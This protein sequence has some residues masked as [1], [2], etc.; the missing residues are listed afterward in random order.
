MLSD[1]A[2]PHRFARDL[3]AR[4]CCSVLLTGSPMAAL[5]GMSVE[6]AEHFRIDSVEEGG[7]SES[8]EMSSSDGDDEERVVITY[9]QALPTPPSHPTSEYRATRSIA[10]SRGRSSNAHPFTP[11]HTRGPFSDGSR[12]GSKGGR[13]S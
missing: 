6:A 3:K 4:H 5:S 2:L 9:E 7:Q 13:R 12:G 10:R 8:E 1:D 11:V